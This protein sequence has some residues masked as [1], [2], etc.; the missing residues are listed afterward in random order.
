MLHTTGWALRTWAALTVLLA[1]FVGLV[2]LI[3][4]RGG[5]IIATGIGAWAEIWLVRAIAR[6]WAYQA[7]G[8]WWWTR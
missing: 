2:W 8:H 6:E 7:S 1:V 3:D 4:G 5:G